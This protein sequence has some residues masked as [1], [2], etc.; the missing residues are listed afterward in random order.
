MQPER[1]RRNKSDFRKVLTW[2][3]VTALVLSILRLGYSY[4]IDFLGQVGAEMFG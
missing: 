3:M 4:I 1:D 2:I